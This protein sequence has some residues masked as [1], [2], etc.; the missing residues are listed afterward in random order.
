MCVCVCVCVRV[1][2][3]ACV[4]ACVRT[5]VRA[6]AR[7][8]VSVCECVCVLAHMLLKSEIVDDTNSVIH[9]CQNCAERHSALLGI[10]AD[11]NKRP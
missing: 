7:V 2:A 10:P 5:R 11:K 6:R 3:Y 4:R 1:R 9:F 8:C